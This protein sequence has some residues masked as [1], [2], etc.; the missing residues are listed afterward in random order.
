[1]KNQT[2][3]M[4]LLATSVALVIGT[5]ACGGS[6][7]TDVKKD[8]APATPAGGGTSGAP[9]SSGTTASGGTSGN[10]SGGTSGTT[11][12]GTS[13]TTSGGTPDAAADAPA[14]NCVAPGY[15]GNDKK[16]GAYCD[17]DVSC[18]FQLSPF[19]VC[20]Y[21]HDPTN[22][23]LFCT[24]P[25]SKDDECGTGAYCMHDTAGSGCVPTQCGGMPGM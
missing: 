25:C 11:S 18:P 4:T 16:I 5:V 3:V 23:H 10:T 7:S 21:G 20:T 22:T 24:S 13:G 9:S 8:T 17:K 19:L 14:G 1:M 6:D 2:I 12:G 15:A